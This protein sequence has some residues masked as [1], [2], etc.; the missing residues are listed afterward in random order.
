MRIIQIT[1]LIGSI[2]M[3]LHCLYTYLSLR[4]LKKDDPQIQIKTQLLYMETWI[5][6]GFYFL[7]VEHVII[8]L[9]F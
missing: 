8:A 4:K 1:K 5:V 6:I 2:L 7:F 9:V 3:S